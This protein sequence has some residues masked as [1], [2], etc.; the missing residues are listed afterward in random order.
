MCKNRPTA[1]YEVVM[2]EKYLIVG[3]SLRSHVK[4]FA[5]VFLTLIIREY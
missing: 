5:V 2:D 1:A 3:I 4:D